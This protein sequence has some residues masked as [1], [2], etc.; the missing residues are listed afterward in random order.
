MKWGL[1]GLYFVCRCLLDI[2][3]VGVTQVDGMH[4]GMALFSFIFHLFTMWHGKF[5]Q[6]L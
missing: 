3:S 5:F 1:N 6:H 4:F 2:F